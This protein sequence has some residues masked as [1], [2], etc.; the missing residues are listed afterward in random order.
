MEDSIQSFDVYL[1][2]LLW[3][4]VAKASASSCITILVR[5]SPLTLGM[6]LSP[7]QSSATSTS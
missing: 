5:S 4:I 3:T 7:T 2:S 6:S 1:M